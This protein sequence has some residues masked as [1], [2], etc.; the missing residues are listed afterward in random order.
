MKTLCALIVGAFALVSV[1]TT[2][3]AATKKQPSAAAT[4][5][6]ACEAQAKKKYSMVHPFKRRAYVKNCMKA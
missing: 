3:D 5:Q 6:A 4:K 1:A 2:A